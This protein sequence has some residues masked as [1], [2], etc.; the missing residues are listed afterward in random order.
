MLLQTI[1]YCSSF[2]IRIRLASLANEFFNFSDHP[3]RITALA[4]FNFMRYIVI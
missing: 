2:D 3:K 4:S 1:S